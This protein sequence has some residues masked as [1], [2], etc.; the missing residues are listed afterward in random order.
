MLGRVLAEARDLAIMEPY[1]AHWN[2]AADILAE[3]FM[4]SDEDRPILQAALALALAFET[5]QLLVDKHRLS[6][7]QAVELVTRLICKQEQ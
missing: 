2:R 1:H 6:D 3:P 4:P 5:W 7:D